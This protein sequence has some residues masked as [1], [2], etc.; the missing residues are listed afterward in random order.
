MKLHLPKSLLTAVMALGVALPM[1]H[2]EVTAPQSST[3]LSYTGT[4][5]TMSATAKND[6]LADMYVSTIIPA[7][8][9][10]PAS[11]DVAGEATSTGWSDIYANSHFNTLRIVAPT[12]Y[13]YKFNNMSIGGLIVEESASGAKI[14]SWSSAD[15]NIYYGQAGAT[16]NS[17]FA[18]S[19]TLDNTPA[20]AGCDIT[21]AGEQNWYINPGASA[22]T[23]ALV[24]QD[25]IINN[26]TWNVSGAGKLSVNTTI[27]NTNGT[28]AL[29]GGATLHVTDINNL[30]WSCYW[31]DDAITTN[32]LTQV[33]KVYTVVNG[34]TSNVTSITYGD[35]ATTQAL[36]DNSYFTELT[37]A[38]GVASDTTVGAIKAETPGLIVIK[39][40]ATLSKGG[41]SFDSAQTLAGRGTYDLGEVA[42]GPTNVAPLGN[43][44]LGEDWTGTVSL[45]GGVFTANS[46]NNANSVQ[47]INFNSLGNAHSTVEIAE[48]GLFGYLA[49]NSD[50]ST[51]FNTNIELTGDLTLQNGNSRTEHIFAGKISG[52]GALNLSRTGGSPNKF[53][54]TND[55][56]G[57]H[58][59]LNCTD[60]NGAGAD[61]LSEVTLRGSATVVDATINRTGA[62]LN[63]IV[64][65]ASQTTTFKKAV[66]VSKLT[67]TG[68]A[69]G[70]GVKVTLTG[71]EDGSASSI[72]SLAAHASGNTI[73]VQ[74]GATLSRIGSKSGG[75]ITLTGAGTYDMKGNYTS[76]V[77]GLDQAAWTGKVVVAGA[78]NGFNLNNYGNANSTIEIGTYTTGEGESAQT[79]NGY[80]GYLEQYSN[81]YTANLLLTGDMT[82]NNG[83][84]GNTKT[85]AGDVSGA[86]NFVAAYTGADANKA[87]TFAQTWVFS[88]DVSGWNGSF[89]VDDVD[90]KQASSATVKFTGSSTINLANISGA[91]RSTLAVTISDAD[92]GDTKSAVA[93]N[94]AIDA[95]SLTVN[96]AEGVALNN[97]VNVE[98]MD[99]Q[100]ATKVTGTGDVTVTNTLTLNG[101]GA[102]NLTGS[103]VMTGAT[104]D[105]SGFTLDTT[106]AQSTYTYTLAFAE[107]GI[108][109]DETINFTGLTG[110]DGYTA[111]LSAMSSDP[112]SS[113]ALM[114]NDTKYLVLTLEKDVAPATELT[115]VTITGATGYADGVLTL[116]TNI[117]D[118]SA[119]SGIAST[120]AATVTDSLW[121]QL[122]EQYGIGTLVDVALTTADGST[123]FDLNG[124]DGNAPVNLTINGIGTNNIPAEF[125]NVGGV[126]GAVIGSYMTAYIPEPTST[127]LSLLALAALAVRRRRK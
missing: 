18:G 77:T 62:Y 70:E 92:Q 121:Q 34:G 46:S 54:F 85:F 109:A 44:S 117:A 103:L 72:S 84:G 116:T 37:D 73:E 83:W 78:Q 82:I 9:E 71:A 32:G 35:S 15:R 105:L 99:V 17:Y 2:A 49:G 28:L 101:A 52:N 7:E 75:D 67:T 19:F 123:Y 58:G 118:L 76:N 23:V 29:S 94:S 36:T 68:I 107:G 98:T 6:T 108:T 81:T 122:M 26:A 51:T 1:V 33:N 95:N 38:Y 127:T 13:G 43:V 120:L 4:V 100:G 89:R 90:G 64:D 5:Y 97:T 80:T 53:V 115:Q 41:D 16:S 125:G 14:K 110:I 126:E 114:A 48:G 57:W 39:E 93:V 69:L 63:L 30:A 21:I 79:V 25:A 96:A 112:A 24:A 42:K 11:W 56:S 113:V 111:T 31:S 20:N 65:N 74:Q 91:E 50:T 66:T 40:G 47:N 86:G 3:D 87:G 102:L 22:V 60:N 88:G 55:I 61:L 104:V 12:T 45:Y 10:T 8:G 119:Y 124:V 27:D 59:A 106:T